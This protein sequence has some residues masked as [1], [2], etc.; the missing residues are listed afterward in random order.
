MCDSNMG[1]NTYPISFYTF[2]NSRYDEMEKHFWIVKPPNLNNGTGIHVIPNDVNS[3]PTYPTC[4]QSYIKD[5]LL[6]NGF[7]VKTCQGIFPNVFQFDICL[8]ILVTSFEPLRINL[9]DEG[10][11]RVATEE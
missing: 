6:I 3:I 10:L 7:K 1:K 2:G 11:V 9:Y 5:P 4:V 8:Y